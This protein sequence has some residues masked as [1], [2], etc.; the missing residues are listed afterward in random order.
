LS[1][2]FENAGFSKR[3]EF[4]KHPDYEPNRPQ[5]DK[6][7]HRQKNDLDHQLHRK[8]RLSRERTRNTTSHRSGSPNAEFYPPRSRY[9]E[10]ASMTTPSGKAPTT[11]V[12][13]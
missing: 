13:S 7:Q 5:H 3:S 2:P 6:R 11:S 10:L 12:D 4:W 8:I 9:S 1:W